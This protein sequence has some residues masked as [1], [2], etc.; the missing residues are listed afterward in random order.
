MEV[1]VVTKDLEQNKQKKSANFTF[2][3]NSTVLQNQNRYLTHSTKAA[4]KAEVKEH[5]GTG[6]AS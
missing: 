1:I 3:L 6:L 4:A 2:W 5:T